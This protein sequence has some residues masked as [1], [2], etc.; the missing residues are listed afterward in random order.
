MDRYMAR[1]LLASHEAVAAL[2]PCTSSSSYTSKDM[3]K[4]GKGS[5]PAQGVLRITSLLSYIPI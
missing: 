1:S 4:E 3:E 2:S 5:T